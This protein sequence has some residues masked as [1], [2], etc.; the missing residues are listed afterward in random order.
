MHESSPGGSPERECMNSAG[1]ASLFFG[2]IFLC[3]EDAGFELHEIVFGAFITEED[4]Q[5]GDQGG[6]E[7]QAQGQCFI[8]EGDGDIVKPRHRI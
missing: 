3:G 8:V 2:L 7:G 1:E 4:R 5:A 6:A